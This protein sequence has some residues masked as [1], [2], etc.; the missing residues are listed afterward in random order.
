M[1]E[2]AKAERNAYYRAWRAKNKEK[3]KQANRRY[4]EK[5]AKEAQHERDPV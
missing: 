5:K 2:K 3:I 1:S 4:W